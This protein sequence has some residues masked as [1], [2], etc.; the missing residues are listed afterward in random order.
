[1]IWIA[2]IICLLSGMLFYFL[3]KNKLINLATLINLLWAVVIL[4]NIINPLDWYDISVRAQGIILLGVICINIGLLFGV[5]RFGASS[6]IRIA[7]P[8]ENQSI[9]S[10]KKSIKFF[11]ALQA[12]LAIVML[13][14][15]IK[16]VI[17]LFNNGF[18]MHTLRNLYASGGENGS[19]M[20]TLE[21]LA[22][23]HYI[24]IPCSMA[25]VLLNSILCFREKS[26]QKPLAYIAILT[27]E[28]SII[29]AARTSMF[30]ALASLIFNYF[31]RYKE[32]KSVPFIDN[33]KI[34]KAVKSMLF[35]ASVILIIMTM[36]RT[37]SNETV[38][39]Y[40]SKTL[41]TYFGGGIRVFDQTIQNPTL[42]GLDSYSFG[43]CTFAGLCSI[44][45]TI[46]NYMMAPLGLN[47]L[48]IGHS[49][50]TIVQGYIYSNVVIGPYTSLNAFPT[51]LY[52]FARDGGAIAIIIM[53]MV[54][55][56]LLQHF[57][58]RRKYKPTLKNYFLFYYLAYV[59]V[60]GLCWWEPI[61]T[62]FWMILFWG[63]VLTRIFQGRTNQRIAYEY[64]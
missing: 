42:Y 48:P 3:N 25:C 45:D 12:V 9:L 35:G 2:F 56:A 40:V 27:I 58:K 22:Y 50:S 14:L 23:I 57:R 49:T 1:M 32:T 30:F 13:P 44:F 34:K 21:R 15:V 24:V 38:I 51:M 52:Y 4:I 59:A 36:L 33:K 7:L 64:Y 61:R 8:T 18:D 54:Y 20:T 43:L 41:L 19:Y 62:E 10:S 53:C 63:I 29:S 55:M 5:V 6:P 28:M 46:N 16:A 11:F 47:I 31:D 17:I 39:T 60:M 26:W 37:N